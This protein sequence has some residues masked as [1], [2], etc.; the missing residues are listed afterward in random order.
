MAANLL[1]TMAL[2]GLWHGAGWTFLLWGLGHGIWLLLERWTPDLLFTKTP[3]G[4]ALKMFLV[5]QGV[6]LLWI[7]FRAP[8][9]EIAAQYYT[10]L[11]SFPFTVSS[12]PSILTGWLI[13]FAV[14]QWPLAWT[15]KEGH[16]V[17]LP[18]KFQWP[19]AL[20]CC[21]MILAYAGARVD[22]IY[23]TF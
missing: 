10:K 17:R 16:F 6:C 20:V 8:T 18:L 11:F 12:T 2:A 22:F 5:F 1:I 15:F 19:L 14:I 13:A 7:L 9:L 21:Y 3:I 23:F 4:K